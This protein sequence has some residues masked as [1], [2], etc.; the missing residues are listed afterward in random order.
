MAGIRTRCFREREVELHDGNTQTATIQVL[1]WDSSRCGGISDGRDKQLFRDKQG[2]P[3]PHEVI[4]RPC[5]AQAPAKQR[6]HSAPHWRFPAKLTMINT[7]RPY[8][9]LPSVW[10]NL[11]KYMYLHSTIMLLKKVLVWPESSIWNSNTT[12]SLNSTFFP[13]CCCENFHAPA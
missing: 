7:S 9:V 4:G 13:G 5:R 1:S 3:G 11:H 10:G 8:V 6:P 2:D 12:T